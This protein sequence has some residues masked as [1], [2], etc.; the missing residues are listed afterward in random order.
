MLLRLLNRDPRPL[1][2]LIGL[3]LRP[4]G[5]QDAFASLHDRGVFVVAVEEATAAA[6][7]AVI[8]GAVV[9]YRVLFAAEHAAA[10]GAIVV[11]AGAGEGVGR[12]TVGGVVSG[13]GAEE[14]H[15]EPVIVL[16]LKALKAWSRK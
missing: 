3:S 4:L 15:V 12:R 13:F 1:K 14:R 10:L 8:C 2:R 16:R 7:T 5:T 9:D 11:L 6:S